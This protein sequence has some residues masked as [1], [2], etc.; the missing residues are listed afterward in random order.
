LRFVKIDHD[1]FSKLVQVFVGKDSLCYFGQ[2]HPLYLNK[3]HG[4]EKD[5]WVLEGNGD[6][7]F[8]HYHPE[9]NYA[10]L[11]KFPATE[12]DI[13]IVVDD[14]IEIEKIEN[15]IRKKAGKN[16]KEFIFY[17]Q[18]QGDNIDQGKRSLTFNLVFQNKERTLKDKE[19]DKSMTKVHG[20]L[21]K[22]INAEL[23]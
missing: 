23:R 7:L 19:V 22:E 10:E 5:I 15:I 2:L 18:Y 14:N 16:L 9:I 21:K 13:S 3:V 6:N 1:I 8:K 17:D 20:A 4:I 11:P 12:R